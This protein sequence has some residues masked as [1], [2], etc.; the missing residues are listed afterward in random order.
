M[1]GVRSVGSATDQQE[2]TCV[3][4]RGREEQVGANSSGLSSYGGM[5]AHTALQTASDRT[6]ELLEEIA[7]GQRALQLRAQVAAANR[8]STPEQVEEAFQ[9][10]CLRATRGCRGQTM[11]EVYVW[12][13]KT[14]GTLLRDA[15]ERLK[16]EVLIDQSATEFLVEDAAATRPDEEIIRREEHAELDALTRTILD[17]LC[18]RERTI[19]ILHSHGYPRKEIAQRLGLTPRVVKRSVEEVLATGRSQ[20]A[21]FTG[22]GCADGHQLVSRYAFGLVAGSEARKAQLHLATCE[23]CGAMYERLDVWRERV[24]VLLPVP[25]VAVEQH[26]AIGRLV[27]SGADALAASD[28]PSGVRRQV[29]DTTAHIR[30]HL[31]SAYI[32]VTDPSPLA[33]VRPGAMAAAVVGCIAVGSGATYCVQQNAPSLI[34]IS[35]EPVAKQVHQKASKPQESRVATV[36]RVVAARAASTRTSTSA[37]VAATAR[38]KTASTK[39]QD[40]A[41]KRKALEPVHE[42]E[43]EPT[44]PIGTS[45]SSGSAASA[46]SSAATGTSGATP[47]ASEPKP[48][49]APA[50]EPSEFEG[51]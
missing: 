29:A 13:R 19:A 25:P 1:T 35:E 21:K 37:S 7:G 18:E 4:E 48:A 49:P 27:Q 12:L 20:L 26:D 8:G 41:P 6:R 15:R 34:G 2:P 9:E 32:R 22:Y 23:R 31:T 24:A 46:A 28:Q 50:N 33:G 47:Q 40:S 10:A 30:E 38:T 3:G 16:R 43:F 45:V 44:A 11:G 36:P 14:T 42:D 5:A 17:R 39:L 51:P